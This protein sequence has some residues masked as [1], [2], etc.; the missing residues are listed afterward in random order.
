MLWGCTWGASKCVLSVA[1]YLRPK[2]GQRLSGVRRLRY[3][4]E[5]AE[6]PIC[7]TYI[8]ICYISQSNYLFRGQNKDETSPLLS[9]FIKLKLP[10]P[11]DTPEQGPLTL[12]KEATLIKK[13]LMLHSSSG[14]KSVFPN[15]IWLLSNWDN[16]PHHW[17][18]P[19]PSFDQH[20]DTS[21]KARAMPQASKKMNV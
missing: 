13:L 6:L 2:I 16:K 8:F 9:H 1:L 15:I 21:G 12:P 7:K 4:T 3:P 11:V 17:W 19:A 14:E 10:T 5:M 18:E 20:R